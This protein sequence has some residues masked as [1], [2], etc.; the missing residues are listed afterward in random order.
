MGL[1]ET[2]TTKVNNLNLLSNKENTILYV[3][4][5]FVKAKAIEIVTDHCNI[6]GQPKIQ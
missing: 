2:T 4:P 5:F 1:L 3:N 6:I